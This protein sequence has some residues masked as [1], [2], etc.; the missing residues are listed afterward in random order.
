[1]MYL[2]VI[3]LL[4]RVYTLVCKLISYFILFM[5]CVPFYPMPSYIMFTYQLIKLYP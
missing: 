2:F 5:A 3:V 4:E 1:M